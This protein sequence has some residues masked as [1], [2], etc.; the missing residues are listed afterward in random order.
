[1]KRISALFVIFALL[2]TSCTKSPEPVSR[3][4]YHL[5]NTVIT[6]SLYDTRDEALLDLC[7]DQIA[8]DEKLFSKTV[9]GSDIDRINH[10]DGQP[11]TVS[12]ETA[13]LLQKAL[14]YCELSGGRFDI[15]I[16][17]LSGL[18]DFNSDTPKMPSREE[19]AEKLPLVDYRQIQIEGNTVQIPKGFALDLGGIAKGYIADRVRTLLLE[20]GVKSAIINLGGNILTVGEKPDGEPFSI[21][22]RKPFRGQND[23]ETTVKV[24]GLSVV[25]SGIYERYFEM[26]GKFYHHILDPKTGQ[27]YDNGLASVTIIS[28]DST[29]GDA[30][31]TAL[32][33]MGAEE[34]LKTAEALPDVE[35]LFIKTDGTVLKT[36]GF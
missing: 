30:L 21:G 14:F 7:F 26:D 18:W 6:I 31:S 35:A 32:F 13:E 9:Q 25:T 19:I 27:P 1:M 36:E 34:G 10:G 33:A 17:P 28:K 12:D 23:L 24:R 15:S 4:E 5:L 16:A 29:D 11:V 20:N 2:L 8:R 22:I 3:T